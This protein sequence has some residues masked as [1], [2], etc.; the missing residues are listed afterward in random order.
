MSFKAQLDACHQSDLRREALCRDLLL[1]YEKLESAYHEKC[2][3]YDNEVESRRRWQQEANACREVANSAR[4]S[5]ESNPFVLALIDGDGAVFTDALVKAGAEGGSDAA[6]KLNMEIRNHV[7]SINEAAG[8]HWSIMVNIYAN[9]EGLAKKL[10]ACGIIKA[11]GELN[12]FIR[13]FSLNQSLFNF[14]D[15]GSGKERADHKIKEMFRLFVHNQQ[16]KHIIF[17]GCHDNGYLPNLDPYKRTEAASRISL[18]ETYRV[19]PGFGALN[20]R[21]I[22]FPD[23]FRSEPLPER[24]PMPSP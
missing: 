8:S 1:H 13:A 20:F 19:Q 10:T 15:V 3:D 18:L 21:I 5:M 7:Q 16:C 22:S 4:L 17:G 24:P 11:P 2:T 6:H 14:I 12:A 23:L 9:L